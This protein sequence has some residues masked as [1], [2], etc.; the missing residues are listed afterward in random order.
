MKPLWKRRPE[1]LLH[2]QIPKPM[3]GLAPREILGRAW[4]D[5]T[6]RAAY[7]STRFHCIACGVYKYN[8]PED[9]LCGHEVYSIDY[10]L[11][12]MEYVET[13]PLCSRCHNFI[14]SGRLSALRDQGK[15]TESEYMSV[16]GHGRTVL[17]EAGL[18]LSPPYSG[19]TADWED[20]R[21][22]IDGVEYPPKFKT[23]EDWKRAY[24]Y[25]EDRD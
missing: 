13:I 12:R 22:V 14:H 20:W 3:H 1:V 4:W 7:K 11:G 24:R 16:L 21:L 15:I 18:H 17:Y 5:K 19:P 10:L 8:T 6:R 25:A 23:F 2:G 9:Y